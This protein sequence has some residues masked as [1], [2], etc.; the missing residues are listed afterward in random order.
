MYPP[1]RV[2]VTVLFG[3]EMV[4]RGH[5]IEW[6][7]Q[8]R[9]D[10]PSFYKTKWSGCNAWIGPN[11][12]GK[13]RLCKLQKLLVGLLHDSKIF[14]LARKYNYDYI[15]VKDKFLA[16]LIAIATSKIYATKFIYWLSFPFPESNLN[17]VK[18][19][20]TQY[21]IYHCIKGLTSSIVLYKI[22]LPFADHIFVQSEQMKKEI[23]LKGIPL[24]KIT[25]VPMG[26]V[27][28][29]MPF[30]TVKSKT[31]IKNQERIII[32]LGSLDKDRRIDFL[33]KVLKK[34]IDQVPACW[35][36]LVGGAYDLNDIANLKFQSKTLGI[37]S[38]VIF[39]G[40]LSMK[41]ALNYVNKAEVCLSYIYPAPQFNAASPTKLIEYMAMGK[42]V[43]ANYQPEQKRVISESKGGVCVPFDTDAFA[44]AILDFL[45]DPIKA[46]EMGKRG[47]IWVEKNRSYK[48]IADNLELKYYELYG[49]S[50]VHSE[51]NGLASFETI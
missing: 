26:V 10:N 46:T 2:D 38:S 47:R 24:K 43:V 27:L 17:S 5:T 34:V 42:P 39:T 12:T 7:F 18:S 14:F 16:P 22:I 31:E 23:G 50:Q 11:T 21:P 48:I 30:Q 28:E 8:S 35:L 49:A 4:R 45:E 40:H 37:Q 20:L 15:Q 51:K 36:Y 3:K 1:L 33:L 29:D 44:S 41:E 13:S 32:Y 25:P 9:E 19:G 6:L